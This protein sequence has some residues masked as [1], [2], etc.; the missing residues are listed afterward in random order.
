MNWETT[1]LLL[2]SSCSLCWVRIC[3][4]PPILPQASPLRENDYL[5]SYD[6][7]FITIVTKWLLILLHCICIYH[8]KSAENVCLQYLRNVASRNGITC[9]LLQ[10]FLFNYTIMKM[11][12]DINKEAVQYGCFN[13]LR[14]T[15]SSQ[16]MQSFCCKINVLES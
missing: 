3:V 4:F 11:L 16:K 9:I 6:C 1:T 10:F 15:F 14:L 8:Y 7:I 12:Q 5:P 13:L 2:G